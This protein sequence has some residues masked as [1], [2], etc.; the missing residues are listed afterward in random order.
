MQTTVFFL[1]LL[2]FF[3][4]RQRGAASLRALAAVRSRFP[5]ILLRRFT[6]LHEQTRLVRV[7]RTRPR[8]WETKSKTQDSKSFI[9]C[10]FPAG[11]AGADADVYVTLRDGVEMEKLPNVYFVNKNLSPRPS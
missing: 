7:R 2:V 8:A 10:D 9:S 11:D 5:V 1:L 6:S 4:K 3:D